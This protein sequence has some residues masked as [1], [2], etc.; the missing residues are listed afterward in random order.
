[1]GSVYFWRWMALLFMLSSV[2]I[3]LTATDITAS[4]DGSIVP[5][6]SPI[7]GTIS[8]THNRDDAVDIGSFRISNKLITVEK[9]KDV[10]I[11]PSSPEILT[12]YHFEL[13]PQ[14]AGL[15][16][17][18]S[19][20]VEVAGKKY[21]SLQTGYEV[22]KVSSY[23][24]ASGGVNYASPPP[25]TPTP[26]PPNVV[27]GPPAAP[28]LRLEAS[29][30]G[31]SS[32]YPSQRTRLVYR[33]FF[34]QNVDITVEKLPFIYQTDLVKIGG[35]QIRD[36]QEGGVGAREISQEVEASL[37]GKYTFGPSV[38]EG[39]AYK[40]DA[41][42][43]I[44]EKSDMLH[45]EAPAV[46]IT[47]LPFP[48]EGRPQAF[49]GA[50]GTFT[51]SADI[52]G[53]KEVDVGNDLSVVLKITEAAGGPGAS[54]ITDVPLP[55]V[56]CQPGFVG[57]FRVSDLPPIISVN[58]S[59]KTAMVLIKPLTTAVEEVPVIAFSYFNPVDKKYVTLK[60]K[61]LNIIVKGEPPLPPAPAVP[62]TAVAMKAIEEPPTIQLQLPQVSLQQDDLHN[63]PFAS[64]WA[65]LIV[66]FG[67][68]F[69]AYQ[70]HLKNF[71]IRRKQ[72]REESSA[73][74]LQK[75]QQQGSSSPHYYENL[76]GAV[77]QR[78][79]EAG[80]I[81]SKD[82]PVEQWPK[83]GTCQEVAQWLS[84]VDE[85]RFS[86]R[87]SVNVREL[88]AGASG[89][90][91]KIPVVPATTFRELWHACAPML[92]FVTALIAAAIYA[93]T[94]TP[95]D[96]RLVRA[97]EHLQAGL[98]SPNRFMRQENLLETAK[99]LYGM[100]Q[101]H[102]PT[103]GNGHLDLALGNV[104]GYLGDLSRALWHTRRAAMLR[105]RDETIQGTITILQKMLYLP[106]SQDTPNILSVLSVPEWIQL[107]FAASIAV[108][109]M[110]TGAIWLG[111]R[112]M[113]TLAK[114]VT[115]AACIAAV[116]LVYHRYFAPLNGTLITAANLR[117]GPADTFPSV[118]EL[119][120]ASGAELEVLGVAGEGDWLQVFTKEGSVGYVPS[121][122]LR[123]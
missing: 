107:F 91:D 45:S 53:T 98:E 100:E 50:V 1:M 96:P 4:V 49:N 7:K 65:L 117:A 72:L 113:S 76:M 41:S 84:H 20:T 121:A 60:S 115:I 52:Q 61:P 105:P 94:P 86:G 80:L 103:N 82:L 83:I 56:C 123:L 101:E 28:F 69:V 42:G 58:G 110:A 77:K 118:G 57:T 106:E 17:L 23:Q 39:Y 92:L 33:Y 81:S 31:P 5:E 78:L 66:P 85:E 54:S 70:S 19:I 55:D 37:P 109:G 97:Q 13:P 30:D 112:W 51:F 32:L 79:H 16:A 116:P 71:L 62:T 108:I 34:N 29:V 26:S 43:K 102:K 87:S 64:W 99:F 40:A 36:I 93:I 89:F 18:P 9:I 12:L 88:E 104:Y 67:A 6:G 59:T 74:I 111:W 46:D 44:I 114:C 2:H 21:S 48:A 10:E 27:Q 3:P 68:A 22:D 11:D 35:I 90:F 73:W 38:V 14:R 63:K 8:I 47:V 95:A 120:V 25:S 24:N 122:N 119:P 15:Y 75:A